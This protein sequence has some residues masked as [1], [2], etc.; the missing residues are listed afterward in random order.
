[1]CARVHI[2]EDDGA[3]RHSVHELIGGNG[4]DVASYE[5]PDDFFDRA[6]IGPDDVIILD[7]A[8][9]TGSG[10]D[11]ATRLKREFPG[12]KIIVVSGLRDVSYRK[13]HAAI[14]PA[15]SFRKPLEADALLE[16]VSSQ[17]TDK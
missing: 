3:V 8:F 12:I 17:L 4:F 6:T 10:V 7:L 1:M 16:T 5:N 9:P 2:I 15:A 11:A 13:A 14:A